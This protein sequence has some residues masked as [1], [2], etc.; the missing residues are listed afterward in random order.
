MAKGWI[1]PVVLSGAAAGEAAWYADALVAYQPKGAASLAASYTNLGTSGATNDA[2]PGDAPTFDTSTG[3]T[4]NGTS[5]YLTT[6]LNPN[7]AYTMLVQ[8]TD[9]VTSGDRCVCGCYDAAGFLIQSHTGGNHDYHNGASLSIA[10]G[11]TSGNLGFSNKTAYRDGSAET[12]TI[13]AGDPSALAI[14]IGA[15]NLGGGAAQFFE[16]KIQAFGIWETSLSAGQ[17]ATKAAAMAAL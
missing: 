4:F 8:F 2:A 12:G 11:V 9:G 13:G 14:F 15:L 10:G 3:W 6:A 7:V 16:G 1:V 17:V 5:D